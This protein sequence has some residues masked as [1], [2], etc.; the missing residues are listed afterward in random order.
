MFL[1]MLGCIATAPHLGG[2]SVLWITTLP[3]PASSITKRKRFT[4]VLGLKT[5]PLTVSKKQKVLHY[6]DLT[7][8]YVSEPVDFFLTGY[9]FWVENGSA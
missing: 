4:A 5:T 2:L 7:H 9:A 6:R 3:K 1:L 8:G